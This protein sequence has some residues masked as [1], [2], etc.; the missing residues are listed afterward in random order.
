MQASDLR[1][2]KKFK[3]K[4]Q[5]LLKTKKNRRLPVLRKTKIFKDSRESEKFQL[6]QRAQK[7]FASKVGAE[8]R[9]PGSVQTLSSVGVPK[10]CNCMSRTTPRRRKSTPSF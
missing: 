7:A 3:R 10:K 5:D 2:P 6:S 8:R 4:N 1:D 9:P